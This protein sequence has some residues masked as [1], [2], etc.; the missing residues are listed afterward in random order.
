MFSIPYCRRECKG[1][2]PTR[3]H[4]FSRKTEKRGFR[5]CECPRISYMVQEKKSRFLKPAVRNRPNARVFVSH[6]MRASF[7]VF[8]SIRGTQ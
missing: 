3:V 2:A 5:H 6:M 1:N 8:A 4:C 7:F